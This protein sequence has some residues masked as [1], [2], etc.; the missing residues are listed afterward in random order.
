M[1][2]ISYSL[3][4]IFITGCASSIKYT[5]SAKT[6]RKY[7][8]GVYFATRADAQIIGQGFN[9]LSGDNSGWAKGYG[10]FSVILTPFAIV[11]MPISIVF[12][13]ITSPYDLLKSSK[14]N[15]QDAS[16]I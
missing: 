16:E 4:I 11:D 9:Y 13:T 7:G 5:E 10:F 14:P 2:V 3:A 8:S 6:S 1:Q 12:D 15:E